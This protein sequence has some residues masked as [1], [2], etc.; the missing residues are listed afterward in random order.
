MVHTRK[1]GA[2]SKAGHNLLIDVHSWDATISAGED[3]ASTSLELN[4]DSSSLHVREGKGGV[5]PLGEDDKASIRQTIAEEILEGGPIEFRSTSVEP[6]ADGGPLEVHGELNLLGTS[7][8]L[9]FELSADEEGRLTGTAKLKQSDFGIKPYSALFGTLKVI[10]EIEVEFDGSAA[11]GLSRPSARRRRPPLHRL[12]HPR[13][14]AG[15]VE[16]AHPE[17]CQRVDHG[18]DDRRRRADRRRLADSL[19]AER[20]VRRWGHGEVGLPVGH[21]DRGGDQVVHQRAAEAVAV[22]VEGDHLHQRHPDAVGEAAVDLPFDDHRVDPHPA[23]VDR[24][25]PPHGHLRRAGVDVDHAEVG[26]E[27]EGQVRRVVDRFGVE[28]GLDPLGQRRASRARRPRSRR[29]SRP[30]RGRP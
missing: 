11:G 20:V 9:S 24:D 30:A 6:S 23:V 14:G 5:V 29:S 3:P 17:G 19:G 26:A 12:P 13:R 27:G 16:V 8:P 21:L 22:L 10:D 7:R 1:A 18:V 28:P 2:A 4:A 25:E 15:H